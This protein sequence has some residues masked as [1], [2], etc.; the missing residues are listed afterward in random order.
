MTQMGLV[1]QSFVLTVPP[2]MKYNRNND[3]LVLVPCFQTWIEALPF[4][5]HNKIQLRRD[6]NEPRHENTN[7]VDADQVQHKVAC[8][9]TEDG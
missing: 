4:A 3:V 6:P 7:N 9:V 2:P 5:L 1:H 8:T